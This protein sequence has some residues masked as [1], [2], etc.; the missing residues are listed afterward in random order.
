MTIKIPNNNK[1]RVKP[2]TQPWFRRRY[3]LKDKDGKVIE[4]P[5]QAFIRVA[6]TIAAE[7]ARYGA[8]NSQVRAFANKLYKV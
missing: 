3:L 1:I 4:T 8:T 6:N 5:E 7:E 2:W